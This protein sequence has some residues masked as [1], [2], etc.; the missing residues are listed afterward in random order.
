ML[1]TLTVNADTAQAAR[2]QAI[3][4]AR[5]MGYSRV[6]MVRVVSGDATNRTYSVQL[7]ATH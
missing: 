7:D 3:A 6:G 4:Q 1:M 2:E 5:A